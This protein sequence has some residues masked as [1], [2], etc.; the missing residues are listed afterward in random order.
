MSSNST[1]EKATNSC[2]LAVLHL[3]SRHHYSSRTAKAQA[4]RVVICLLIDLLGA[5]EARPPL[6]S[7]RRRPEPGA[8]WQSPAHLD[9]AYPVEKVAQS[10][11]QLHYSPR[12]TLQRAIAPEAARLRFHPG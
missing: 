11:C 5:R 10:P 2:I 9:T 7:P 4:S 3:C 1:T 8:D 6:E 12:S